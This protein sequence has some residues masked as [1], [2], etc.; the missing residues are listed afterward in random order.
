[1]C[2]IIHKPD[3]DSVIDEFILDNAERINPDGFGIVYTDNNECVRTMDYQTAREL[4]SV[5]RPFVAHYRYATR[6]TVNKR[7]CHPYV[8][9]NVSPDDTDV[10]RLFSNGTVADLGDDNL[11]DTKVVAKMLERIPVEH[12][13]DVLSMTETRFAICANSHVQRFGDWH[14]RNGIYYSKANCFHKSYTK[15]VGYGYTSNYHTYK[16]NRSYD[17]YGLYDDYDD[18]WED[19]SVNQGTSFNK[20]T[21][22][23]AYLADWNDNHLIAVYGTLKAGRGNH[24]TLGKS[25]FRGTGKTANPYAMQSSSIPFVFEHVGHDKQQITV[26]VYDAVSSFSREDIDF[27]EG[28]PTNYERKETDIVMA[29]G[30]IKTCWLYFANPSYYDKMKPTISTY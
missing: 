22:M 16:S 13:S 29:D 5:A 9:S 24:A 4:I 25:L 11:C 27:L 18:A 17:A 3:A 7:G 15:H 23:P 12:W 10:V 21:P 6:G 14:E 20:T 19:G 8:I 30:S 26:E 1:M 2:L 28:H